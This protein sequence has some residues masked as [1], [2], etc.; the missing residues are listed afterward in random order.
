[1]NG[2]ASTIALP[3]EVQIA[4]AYTPSGFRDALR[5]LFE[6][7]ARLARIVAGTN[8]PMLGQMR[9]A[10]WRDILG[11][12]V[13]ERPT[14]DAVLDAIADFWTGHESG[15]ITLVDGWEHMLADPP[16]SH[17]AAAGFADG[18]AAAM[19][20]YA[21]MSEASPDQCEAVAA[22]AS[23][24]AIAD[25]ASHIA[26]AKERLTMLEVAAR[27]PKPARLRGPLRGIAVLGALAQRS[28]D[29]GGTPL[30]AGRGASLVAMRAG[31]A[32]R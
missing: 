15:L 8:E 32:G 1:M 10:W 21:K 2:S 17:D 20:S 23:L 12:P 18:R 6:V 25:A 14:G 24:W 27:L 11:T 16:L 19:S 29:A 22:N 4:L 13:S 7:D 9:L 31:L 5:T 3:A 28:L 26:D 30:M